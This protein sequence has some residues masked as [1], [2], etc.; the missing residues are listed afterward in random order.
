MLLQY[1]ATSKINVGLHRGNVGGL[2]LRVHALEQK[3]LG[4]IVVQQVG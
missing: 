2:G 1:R 4:N 3:M